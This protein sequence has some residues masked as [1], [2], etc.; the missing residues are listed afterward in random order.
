GLIEKKQAALEAKEL[1]PTSVL[2][3]EYARSQT[4]GIQHH[5]REAIRN[6][7][8][9]AQRLLA[10]IK[11]MFSVDAEQDELIELVTSNDIGLSV[12]SNRLPLLVSAPASLSS[13]AFVPSLM[14]DPKV[15]EHDLKSCH[16]ELVAVTDRL[17]LTTAALHELDT[18]A[19]SAFGVL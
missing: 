5:V 8:P 10:A 16:P 17:G 9:D 11:A 1:D 18:K 3:V 6:S 13:P 19:N 4:Y 15:D 12:A 14:L 2:A 7:S